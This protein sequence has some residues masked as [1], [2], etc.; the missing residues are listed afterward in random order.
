MEQFI[1]KTLSQFGDTIGHK[2][3]Y[4]YDL[5]NRF[6]IINDEYY[7]DWKF[8]QTKSYLRDVVIPHKVAVFNAGMWLFKMLEAN[9]I[10]ILKEFTPS[11]QSTHYSRYQ[12]G[13][14]MAIHDISKFSAAE[15]WPYAQ[16]DFKNNQGDHTLFLRGWH[17]H[18]HHND[19]H[20][21]YWYLPARSG[22]CN[23]LFMPF[24]AIVEMV[25][26]WI[27]AGEV[28][29]NPIEEWLPKNLPKFFWHQKTAS[30]LCTILELMGFSPS[31]TEESGKTQ[32]IC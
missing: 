12:W 13:T 3:P 29:G 19:H 2:E 23:L 21:E 4:F 10:K 28:Y 30:F 7:D 26:D 11:G 24:E 6:P 18:I 8:E 16:Y 1:K 32:I 9:N 22:E 31:I 17:H 27:G 20:P 14:K 15:A 5:I 25:A